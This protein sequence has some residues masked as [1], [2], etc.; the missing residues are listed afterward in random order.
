MIESNN[1]TIVPQTALG[2][3]GSGGSGKDPSRPAWQTAELPPPLLLTGAVNGD[4][5][6]APVHAK[7]SIQCLKDA[8][9]TFV[10]HL[11]ASDVVWLPLG[12]PVSL[13]PGSPSGVPGGSPWGPRVVPLGS[14]R[15]PPGVSL[16]PLAPRWI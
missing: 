3:R 1:D 4:T 13:G 2:C 9:A 12:P 16:V 15:P 11:L 10:F 5:R 8:N 14:L 7:Q 6:V